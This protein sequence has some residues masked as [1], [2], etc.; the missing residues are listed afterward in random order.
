MINVAFSTFKCN[1]VL[2]EQDHITEH[3]EEVHGIPLA[4]SLSPLQKIEVD[5]SIAFV[6]PSLMQIEE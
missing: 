6:C 2:V 5:T 3:Y 4:T 1:I